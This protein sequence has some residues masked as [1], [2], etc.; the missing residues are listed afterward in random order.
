MAFELRRLRHH[1]C[2]VGWVELLLAQEF[3]NF[4][5]GHAVHLT[6]VHRVLS[7]P[8]IERLV[9]LQP[10]CAVADGRHSLLRHQ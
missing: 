8:L 3:A 7:Q 6:G 9:P 2:S 10:R 1:L 4:V 5:L